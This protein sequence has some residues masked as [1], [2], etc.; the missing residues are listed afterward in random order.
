MHDITTKTESCS[1]TLIGKQLQDYRKGYI[2]GKDIIYAHMKWN[3]MIIQKIKVP[4]DDEMATTQTSYFYF[5]IIKL[6][7]F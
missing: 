7:N 1:I 2:R 4:A 6:I 3:E 5:A